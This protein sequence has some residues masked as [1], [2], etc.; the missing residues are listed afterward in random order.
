[1]R[2]QWIPDHFVLFFDEWPGY[3]ASDKRTY[4]KKP[5]DQQAF[6]TVNTANDTDC[7][8]NLAHLNIIITF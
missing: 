1:M 5:E 6:E 8:Q 7:Q 4:Q 2:K 3:E